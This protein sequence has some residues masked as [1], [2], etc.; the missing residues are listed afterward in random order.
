MYFRPPCSGCS[1]NKISTPYT[2]TCF[3][4]FSN[5]ILFIIIN[6]VGAQ[7]QKNIDQFFIFSLLMFSF[8]LFLRGFSV[9]STIFGFSRLF[10]NIS[11]FNTVTKIIFC[12]L[13]AFQYKININ[14]CFASVYKPCWNNMRYPLRKWII[15]LI[16]IPLNFP[17]SHTK[18]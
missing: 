3:Y 13:F 15:S 4:R 5:C 2:F 7:V 1:S 11:A 16:K 9:F 17:R 14:K 18:L 8:P 6:K 12:R 10:Q